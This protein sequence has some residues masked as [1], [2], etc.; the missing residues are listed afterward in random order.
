M[1]QNEKAVK[2]T[3]P[4]QCDCCATPTVN[5][6]RIGHRKSCYPC[7]MTCWPNQSRTRWACQIKIV[8]CEAGHTYAT[9]QVTSTTEADVCTVCRD[10]VNVRKSGERHAA[11]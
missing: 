1:S 7:A 10:R 6:W 5:G 4:I 2:I 3:E 9:R 8:N 11:D